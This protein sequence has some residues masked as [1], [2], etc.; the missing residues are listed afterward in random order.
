MKFNKKR[1]II[2]VSC[3]MFCLSGGTYLWM[4]SGEQTATYTSSNSHSL[5]DEALL[6][7]IKNDQSAFESFLKSGGN[8]HAMLPEIDG[9]SLTVAEGI[10]YFERIEFIQYLQKN[11]ISFLKQK[12]DGSEDILALAVAKNNPKIFQAL[13]KE[14]PDLTVT[15]GKEKKNL[16]HLAS[17]HCAHQL[18]DLL[19]QHG[20]FDAHQRQN[21]GASAM[22]LA[23]SG[24]CLPMLTYWKDKKEDFSKEDGR[25]KSALE[26]LKKNKSAGISSFVASIQPSRS[27]AS[28]KPAA[29]KPVVIPDFYKKRKLPKDELVDHSALIEPE[30]RPL[31]TD[32]TAEY[33]EFAD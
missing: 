9:K 20:K 29:V 13:L 24:N 21:N 22:T 10:V 16:L 4:R 18:T 27:P 25:G 8:V 11:K 17:T 28:V 30:I 7:L 5:S 6:A 26:L 14:K 12:M 1:L 32:E 33:S 15:Y 3:L 19:H 2:S 23:A 31:D